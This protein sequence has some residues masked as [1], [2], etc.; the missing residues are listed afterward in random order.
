MPL[1]K[2]ISSPM[3][4]YLIPMPSSGE[5]SRRRI[6]NLSPGEDPWASAK[7]RLDIDTESRLVMYLEHPRIP[8]TFIKVERVDDLLDGDD[9]IVG[10]PPLLAR[11][12]P[13]DKRIERKLSEP[14]DKPAPEDPRVL[15][16][17]TV[18]RFCPLKIRFRGSDL[19][20]NLCRP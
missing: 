16:C 13:D 2:K 5:R 20:G 4:I 17:A 15:I 8:G 18:N 3:R 1:E 14:V 6:L 11:S 9:I 12:I 19:E 7:R 10:T